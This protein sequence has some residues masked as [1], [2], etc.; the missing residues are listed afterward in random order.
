MK[1]L[2]LLAVIYG[3]L[4]NSARGSELGESVRGG[5]WGDYNSPHNP[6]QD[7]GHSG[8]HSGKTDIT[9]GSDSSANADSKTV[10]QIKEEYQVAANTISSLNLTYCSDGAG[11]ADRDASF[12]LG[13]VNYVCE[14]SIA[15]PQMLSAV[16][17]LL[18]AAEQYPEGSREREIEKAKAQLVLSKV[19]NILTN[20]LADYIEARGYT[21]PIGSATRDLWVLLALML[22]AL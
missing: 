17:A 1:I 13:G 5:G 12:N 10:V 11:A 19:N 22:I 21:A 14:I 7:T 9:N 6:G 2:L 15:I 3:L 16:P 8:G 18:K 20:D 4:S